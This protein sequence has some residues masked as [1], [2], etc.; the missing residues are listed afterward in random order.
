MENF[1][2]I[3]L[4]GNKTGKSHININLSFCFPLRAISDNWI[5]SDFITAY[6]HNTKLFLLHIYPGG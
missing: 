2:S 1:L 6:K 4:L 5:L 3:T